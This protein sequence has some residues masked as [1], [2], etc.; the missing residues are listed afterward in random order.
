[1]KSQPP[2][3]RA[4]SRICGLLVLSPLV[5]E[6]AG[7]APVR[8]PARPQAASKGSA[9]VPIKAAMHPTGGEAAVDPAQRMAEERLRAD[10]LAPM[11]TLED[12]LTLALSN[13][14]ARAAAQAAVNEAQAN[15]KVVS[16]GG[17]PSIDLSGST[18]YSKNTASNITA[19]T[20]NQ[21][22]R[23]DQL[24][25]SVTEPI[26]TGGRVKNA[27][28]AARYLAL[29]QIYQ[30]SQVEQNLVLASTLAYLDRLRSEQLLRVAQA[31][32]VVS[33]EQLRVASLRYSVGA[34][35][36]L[37]VLA[38]RTTLAQARIRRT[39]ALA[40][41]VTAGGALNTLLG[42]A[43]E[44]PL[45]LAPIVS[46]NLPTL[47]LVPSGASAV[48]GIAGTAGA[49]GPVASGGVNGAG[50]AA[51]TTSVAPVGGAPLAAG[52]A[53]VPAGGGVTGSAPVTSGTGT[54][55]NVAP[56]APAGTA[57]VTGAGG[58]GA[59]GTGAGAVG[60]V[61][62]AGVT[63]ATTGTVNSA[64]GPGT[65]GAN[66]GGANAGG[67]SPVTGTAG[68][69][70]AGAGT[71]QNLATTEAQIGAARAN[72]EVAKAAQRPQIAA[73]VTGLLRNPATFLGHF[74][75][76]LGLG[77]AQ[78]LFDSRRSKNEIFEAQAALDQLEAV[79]A[80]QRLAVANAID[81]A[82][83]SLESAT[84]SSV[85]TQDEVV[86]AREALRVALVGFRSGVRTTLDVANAQSAQLTAETDAV[87]AR[88]DV[89]SS[90]A[91]LAAAVGIYTAE[92]QRARERVPTPALSASAQLGQETAVLKPVV[93]RKRHK[94][95]GVF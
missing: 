91:T 12:A 77:L 52:S 95:L 94:F 51:P 55:G 25:V 16:A 35:T 1:M 24:A 60:A 23:A 28:Q 84:K 19:T 79:L 73:T 42:R 37:D 46:L 11:L 36:R 15:V 78:T 90:Q 48:P 41:V 14:P 21:F 39:G 10:A 17:K 22:L 26:T 76:S 61:T 18:A 33:T 29:A 9:S 47:P 45:R 66:A 67:A 80:G 72:L 27:T 86:S 62:G 68:A 6:S 32:V 75:A 65:G 54:A 31:N 63:G 3:F 82:L 81:A 57:G 74:G 92:A 88:F 7:A 85:D 13:N 56:G 89:A 64:T 40:A 49:G 50:T 93:K 2:F 58:T 8:V 69:Q 87:N 5:V 44:T 4:G 34:D 53:A 20:P 43:P 71:N 83:V 59:G 70:A 30:L 38:A